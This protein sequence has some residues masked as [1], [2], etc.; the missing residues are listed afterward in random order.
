METI[1]KTNRR[2]FLK[3]GL[4][5]SGGLVLGFHWS[6]SS[7]LA[8]GVLNEAALPAGDINFNS[9]LSISSD[10]VITIFSPNPELGQNIKTSFPMIVA[11]E[12]DADWKKVKVMQAA[13][14]TKKYERQLTGGSG[15]IPHSWERLRKAGAT[16][17]QMLMEAAAKRWN[18]S[19]STLK[20]DTGYVIHPDDRKLTYG[21]LATEASTIPVPTEVKLKDKK[22]FKII[23]QPIHNVDNLEMITG[24][25]L[26]G[27]DFYR[28]GM[29]FAMIQRPA[30]FG[31]KIKSVDATAA[32]A[33]PG[34]VDVVTFKNNVAIVG[35]STWEVNKARKV[36]K[37]EY[38]KEGNIESTSDHD[39]M[40]KELLAKPE[41]TVKRK[42]GD[43][44][45]AFK[46]AAKV[47]TREYQCPFLSHAPMEPMNFFAHVR[48]DGVELVGP[49]QT[50]DM[51]RNA[52]ATLLGIA[53]E[54]ITLELTR[55]GGGFGRRLKADYVLEAAELSSIIKAPVKVI[56]T[57]EDDM[58]GG[59]YRPA[60]RYRFDAALDA[61][62]KLIGYKLRGVGI[63]S[64]NP[65]R[66]D[67][68]PSGAVDNLLIESVEH[69][70]PIT[71]GAWRAPITNFLAFAEQAF[72]DEVALAAKKDPV[73][74]R[75]ELL[76]KAKQSPAG[77]IKYD[78][79]RMKGVIN[80]VAEKSGWGKKKDLAQGFSV[81]FS[82]RS[83]VAQVAEVEMK[84]GTPVL[85]KIF[86][87]SDCGIVVNMSGAKQQVMGGIVDGLGHA[88]YG[89]VTFKD[90][91]A[92]QRNFNNY[93]LIRFREV[94]EVEVHFVDNGIDPTGLGEP[95]L[96]PT[97][98]AVANAIFKATGKR[99]YNQP[100]SLQEEMKAVKLGEKM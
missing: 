99:L 64:G 52:T 26:F 56:W 98:G 96:P 9:Y 87:A 21:E 79:D 8:M 33:L 29:L 11:E 100:F 37:V 84:K 59:S 73:Q 63:N 76:D 5:A 77:A 75:L 57:R 4:T 43:V 50:P 94:P 88:L 47:I 66:E 42:D 35:K 49:S 46:S 81:Y 28:E 2:D 65:T 55:L 70:S 6:N 22:D 14:D 93:R 31:M 82:H 89:Q 18:T 12:L 78:I 38:E 19:A 25:P 44:D 45:A 7:A 3:L 54:K 15:A 71:T 58:M 92:E 51:A 62:G 97:G 13:L 30:S 53:P 27:L 85:K 83:Y 39:R 24:K 36:L 95:A 86:A 61:T 67:N 16:A 80:L 1:S 20:T 10:D 90:G 34:I 74:F 72:L 48:P 17:R 40:F 91:A 68:F 69:Q 60:V 23:G 32:K 41:A